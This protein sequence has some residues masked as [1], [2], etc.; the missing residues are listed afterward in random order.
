LTVNLAGSISINS[1]DNNDI[2]NAGLTL[3]RT[4]P[5]TAL[6]HHNQRSIACSHRKILA[7]R[8][9]SAA[10]AA[11]EAAAQAT[12]DLVLWNS[13]GF[14][15]AGID[16]LPSAPQFAV[17]DTVTIALSPLQSTCR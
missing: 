2:S 16:D 4:Q 5:T 15:L 1:K 9:M 17:G 7:V 14:A 13:S 3:Q 10:D 6:N 8:G 11:A 12:Q